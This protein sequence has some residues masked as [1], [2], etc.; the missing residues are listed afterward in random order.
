MPGRGRSRFGI[1]WNLIARRYDGQPFNQEEARAAQL[2][3][4]DRSVR[5]HEVRQ[6]TFATVNVV[7]LPSVSLTPEGVA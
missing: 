1:A 7:E 3:F 5:S 4:A 2:A 6:M